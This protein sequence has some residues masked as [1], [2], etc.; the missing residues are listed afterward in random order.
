M[1]R[2][3]MTGGGADA[4]GD[5]SS[6]RRSFRPV[7][8]PLGHW[9]IWLV[10]VLL[11]GASIPWYLTPGQVPPIWL[12]LPHWVGISLVATLGIA[13]FTVLVI[14]RYWDEDE[15]VSTPRPD[16]PPPARRP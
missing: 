12:G 2:E 3:P 8:E 11:F 4:P 10:Y 7:R 13:L 15:S 5:D 16:D 1:K 14:Q 9:W 6:G